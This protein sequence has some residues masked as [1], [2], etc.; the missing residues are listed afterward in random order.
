MPALPPDKAHALR[1]FA[2]EVANRN[3][4]V[5]TLQAL[6]NMYGAHLAST[7]PPKQSLPLSQAAALGSVGAAGTLLEAK[8]DVN[9][10]GGNLRTALV[11]A[12][13]YGHVGM[14]SLL[15]AA[16][17]AVDNPDA[18]RRT[19][20]FHAA[21]EG[22]THIISVLL[23]AKANVHA[24]CCM[25][26]TPLSWAADHCRVHSMVALL[27]AKAHLGGSGRQ[28]SLQV[29][30]ARGCLP[31]INVLLAAKADVNGRDVHGNTAMSWAAL[32]HGDRVVSAL[33]EA[34]AAVDHTDSDGRTPLE[35]A[36]WRLGFPR[37]AFVV[38]AAL[39][40][41]KADVEN[42]LR[43]EDSP[44]TCLRK[45]ILELLLAARAGTDARKEAEAHTMP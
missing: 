23:A 6:L 15:L 4:H 14:V 9:A 32:G 20:L 44:F 19:P 8:A 2:L 29:A 3:D 41:A 18:H 43:P 36:A 25:G 33:L 11:E 24:V 7:M 22:C 42:A 10:K 26:H 38:T 39:L 5:Q 45:P 35:I 31:A 37:S 16:K 13:N 1:H 30:V 12:T 21:V 34:K 17:A 27:Q 28:S 40:R